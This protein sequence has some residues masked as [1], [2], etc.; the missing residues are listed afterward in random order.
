MPDIVFGLDCAKK[1][2]GETFSTI[3]GKTS[4]C[5]EVRSWKDGN[6][7]AG[8]KECGGSQFVPINGGEKKSFSC[9]IFPGM[10]T[11][12]PQ[13]EIMLQAQMK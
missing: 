13:Q 2:T 11:M 8:T 6:T 10:T 1:T 4:L 7:G 9:D 5:A 12:Q 3:G